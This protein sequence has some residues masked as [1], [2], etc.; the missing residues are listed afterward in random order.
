MLDWRTVR[1]I[2][3]LGAERFE[4]LGR[5]DSILSFAD[6][7]SALE[8]LN[9]FRDD[10][11]AMARLRARVDGIV[12]DSHRLEPDKLFGQVAILLVSGRLRILRSALQGSRQQTG[13]R[14]NNL[15]AA[16]GRGQSWRPEQLD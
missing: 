8:F 4:L 13:T 12:E 15:H 7:R 1:R 5:G 9:R 16:A 10:H 14:P 2:L 11:S 3:Q 6:G